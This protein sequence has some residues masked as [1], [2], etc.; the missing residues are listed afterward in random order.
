MSNEILDTLQVGFRIRI[1]CPVGYTDER[2]AD[3]Q[4]ITW[5]PPRDTWGNRITVGFADNVGWLR[6]DWPLDRIEV[7]A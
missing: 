6:L 1:T 7:A 2:F 5:L 3:W 4:E